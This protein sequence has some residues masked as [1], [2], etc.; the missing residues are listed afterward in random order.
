MRS[1][2]QEIIILSDLDRLWC[3]LMKKLFLLYLTRFEDAYDSVYHAFQSLEPMLLFHISGI[4]NPSYTNIRKRSHI[5]WHRYTYSYI[6]ITKM[7]THTLRCINIL[8][9][10]ISSGSGCGGVSGGVGGCIKMSFTM[11][12]VRNA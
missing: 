5:E 8:I 6:C 10:K 9:Y 3:G 11:R 4:Y 2:I 7:K 12:Y 1:E